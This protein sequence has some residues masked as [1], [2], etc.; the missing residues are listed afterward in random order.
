MQNKKTMI[1]SSELKLE[2]LLLIQIMY[3]VTYT[4]INKHITDCSPTL[5]FHI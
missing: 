4:N 5:L 2:K 1:H 3:T